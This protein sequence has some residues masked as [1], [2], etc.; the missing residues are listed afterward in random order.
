M[1]KKVTKSIFVLIA[2]SI[3]NRAGKLIKKYTYDWDEKG[4]QTRSLTKVS[5]DELDEGQIEYYLNN[6]F[7]EKYDPNAE[8]KDSKEEK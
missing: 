2:T 4:E 5:S 3:T 1:A 7:I 6:G 8:S